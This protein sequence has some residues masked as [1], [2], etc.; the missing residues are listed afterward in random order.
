MKTTKNRTG[1]SKHILEKRIRAKDNTAEGAQYQ[2][3]ALR[4]ETT[5]FLGGPRRIKI[6][7]KTDLQMEHR[8][9]SN[10]EEPHSDQ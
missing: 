2:E 9:K 5:K 8:Q 3:H 4:I 10:I 1:A 6:A 7:M